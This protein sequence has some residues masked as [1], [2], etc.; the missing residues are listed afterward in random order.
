VLV[1]TLLGL[2]L[3]AGLEL[4]LMLPSPIA[5]KMLQGRGLVCNDRADW[6]A[7]ACDDAAAPPALLLAQ[8]P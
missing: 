3:V 4:L 6:S 5:F 2:L 7:S 1:P 8:T